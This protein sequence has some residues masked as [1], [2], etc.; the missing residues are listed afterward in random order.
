[1]KIA[2]PKTNI[3]RTFLAELFFD[4]MASIVAIELG[5]C[6]QV[7][8]KALKNPKPAFWCRSRDRSSVA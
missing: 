8:A 5:F 2:H 4:F 1:M 3:R 7:V 6:Q